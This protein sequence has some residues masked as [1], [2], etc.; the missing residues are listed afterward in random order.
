MANERKKRIILVWERK[1][2]EP[3]SEGEAT[4]AEHPVD[5]RAEA[6]LLRVV[7]SGF[8]QRVGSGATGSAP[9]AS[10]RAAA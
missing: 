9:T 2:T 6:P 4:V 7:S 5:A 10:L 1:E 3:D 8:G